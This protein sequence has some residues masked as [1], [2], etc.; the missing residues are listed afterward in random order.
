[1]E[2]LSTLEQKN[3]NLAEIEVNEVTSLVG[4][5]ASEISSNDAMPCGVI[6]FVEFLL[7]ECSN[8]LFNVVFFQSLSCAVH[9][10]LLHLLGHI[11]IL[12]NCLPVR[13]FVWL[14]DL[15]MFSINLSLLPSKNYCQSSQS[16]EYYPPTPD[17]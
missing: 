17:N 10:I 9:S 11:R 2:S 16:A 15:G 13:H 5:V 6:L 7:Y 1:M 3:C 8:V 4:H 14:A 12:D